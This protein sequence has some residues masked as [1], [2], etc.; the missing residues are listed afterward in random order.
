MGQR[1]HIGQ[2]SACRSVCHCSCALVTIDLTAA[3]LEEAAECDADLIIAYHPPIFSGIK[4]LTA[5]P[6]VQRAAAAGCVA[7]ADDCTVRTT[8][9]LGFENIT[10]AAAAAV[11]YCIC[12]ASR[13]VCLQVRRVQY[14]H[15][16]GCCTR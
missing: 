7:C 11:T 10:Y 4:R 9:C 12:E 2:L 16:V 6:L 5:V 8:C 3:V 1:L 15:S 14:P 13:W